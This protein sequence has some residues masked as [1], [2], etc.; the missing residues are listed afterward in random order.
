MSFADGAAVHAWLSALHAHRAWAYPALFLGACLETVVPFSLLIPGEMVFLAG[1][2]LAATGT[3][4][5]LAVLAMLYGGGVLGDNCSYW[6]GRHYG[7][8]L[9]RRLARWPLLGALVRGGAYDAGV[10]FFC[11]RG[12]VAVFVARLS[13]PLSWIT[14]ALAGMFRL[15]YRTFLCCNTPAVLI[16]ISEFVFAGYFLA[17]QLPRVLGASPVCGVA[18][19]LGA[20]VLRLARRRR[21]AAG[22]RSMSV[23]HAPRTRQPSG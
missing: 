8:R 15:N 17:H 21:C 2:L 10:A 14:P 12:A 1:A 3:L 5:L 7:E 6:I 19:G 11:R 16:G 4:D 22:P 9:F 18:L 23:Q 13:G 20:L